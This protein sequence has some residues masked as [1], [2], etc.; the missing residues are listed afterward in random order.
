LGK[1]WKDF[2]SCFKKRLTWVSNLSLNTEKEDILVLSS[3]MTV[4]LMKP[5]QAKL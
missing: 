1:D 5:P 3:G 4:F 2:Q